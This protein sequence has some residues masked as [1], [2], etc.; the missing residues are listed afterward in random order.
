MFT[1]PVAHLKLTPLRMVVCADALF[2][3]LVALVYFTLFVLLPSQVRS[4]VRRAQFYVYG[5]GLASNSGDKGSH[6]L[7]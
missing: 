1:P 3:G 5:G 7:A 4:G 6:D 2:L